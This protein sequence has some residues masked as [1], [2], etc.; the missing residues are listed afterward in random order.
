M[1][2]IRLILA[3]VQAV[4]RVAVAALRAGISLIGVGLLG[5]VAIAGVIV[6]VL[7]LGAAG[8]AHHDSPARGRDRQGI[9]STDPVVVFRAL[10]VW[11]ASTYGNSGP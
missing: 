5:A 8:A 3:L 1:T 10:V 6:A 11:L 7:G 4:L 2:V 9:R